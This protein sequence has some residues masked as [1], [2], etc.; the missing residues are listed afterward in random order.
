MRRVKEVLRLAH[1]LGYSS[2]QIRDSVRLGRTTVGEYLARGEHRPRP[3]SHSGLVAPRQGA[4]FQGARKRARAG[5]ALRWWA[6][7]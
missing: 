5:S 6:P 4:S 1:E 2:R 7:R 3:I